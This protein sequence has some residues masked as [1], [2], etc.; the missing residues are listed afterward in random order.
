MNSRF[1]KRISNDGS[2]ILTKIMYRHV[3]WEASVVCSGMHEAARVE[4]R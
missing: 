2:I 3:M 1:E 4:M